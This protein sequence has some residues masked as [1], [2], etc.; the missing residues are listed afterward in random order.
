[1][2]NQ[3]PTKAKQGGLL[4]EYENYFNSVLERICPQ[5][6]EAETDEA[7]KAP[8]KASTMEQTQELADNIDR[9]AQMVTELISDHGPKLAKAIGN[10]KE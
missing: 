6:P 5:K 7:V 10:I 2:D 4:K 3:Q 9:L 1:M 8:K